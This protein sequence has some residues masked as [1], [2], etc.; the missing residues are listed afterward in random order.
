MQS[1]GA[2]VKLPLDVCAQL[3]LPAFLTT[4]ALPP[5]SAQALLLGWCLHVRKGSAADGLQPWEMAAYVDAGAP[6]L[7]VPRG[8]WVHCPGLLSAAFDQAVR[9]VTASDQLRPHQAVLTWAMHGQLPTLIA[10]PSLCSA[11]ARQGR[12][13]FLLHS[14]AVLQAARLEKQRSR[15]R[16]R[17]LL[18]VRVQMQLLHWH[19][20][21]CTCGK[22]RVGQRPMLQSQP[23]TLS[24][25]FCALPAAPLQFE[26][27]AEA[28]QKAVPQLPPATRLR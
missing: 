19:Q 2:A 26:G 24:Y 8:G 13:Q 1:A 16:D 6:G 27:L 17:A 20:S 4:L 23:A 22:G 10:L 28:V 3:A 11:V 12:T 14:A 21:A 9:Q 25:S 7:C 5:L 15:T 18:Q